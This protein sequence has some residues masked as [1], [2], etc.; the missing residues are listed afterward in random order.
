M[1]PMPVVVMGM[2]EIISMTV[3]MAVRGEALTLDELRELC[4]ETMPALVVLDPLAEEEKGFDFLKEAP[5]MCRTARLAAL[6][7]RF[8]RGAMERMFDLG[9]TALMT[10]E[11]EVED[12]RH[13]LHAANKGKKH[14]TPC[15]MDAWQLDDTTQTAPNQKN[16]TQTLS[17]RELQIFT[18]LGTGLSIKETA[19]KAGVSARTVESHEARIKT[20][21]GF[22][23]NT[24]M[25]RHAILY[26]GHSA[27]TP[28]RVSNGRARRPE[29][30]RG[31]P[32]EIN[33]GFELSARENV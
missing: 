23:S 8:E 4:S 18:L 26:V 25:R 24:E 28:R 5:R 11:D 27:G 7:G 15:A 1:S 20:K 13:A 9:V 32:P 2:R 16:I 19:A 10:P 30:P 29:T 17:D 33:H 14:V 3:G 22:R 6:S 31:R 21:L 12:I